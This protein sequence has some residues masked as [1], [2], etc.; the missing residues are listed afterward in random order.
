MVIHALGIV[1]HEAIHGNL[2]RRRSLDRWAAFLAGLPGLVSG[3]AYRVSHL[4][5]H[6]HNRSELDPD[7]FAHIFRGRRVQSVAFWVWAVLG[8]PIFIVHVAVSAMKR[9]TRGDRRA[10]VFEYAIILAVHATIWFL[11][12]RSGRLEI[13]LWAWALPLASTWVI[14]SLRG[15]SEHM[16]TRPEHPLTRTRTI[17]SN[18]LMSFLMLNLNY[19]LDHHLFPGVPWYNLPK[20]H[21]LLEDEYRAA[22]A[23]IYRSY[24]RFAW[25][26]ARR[27]FHGLAPGSSRR[28]Q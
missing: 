28:N 24:L 14:V 1:M 5:H 8:L 23:P 16:L 17:T 7:E 13:I 11:L 4:A 26:A 9:G 21:S 25:D 20:L 3:T 22:G 27:G 2:F 18:R 6:R 19:H 12:A 10:V 15:W